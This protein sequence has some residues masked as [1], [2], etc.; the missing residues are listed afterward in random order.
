MLSDDPF[1]IDH[2]LPDVGMVKYVSNVPWKKGVPAIL[3]RSTYKYRM[4]IYAILQCYPNLCIL[5]QASHGLVK[6]A[7]VHTWHNVQ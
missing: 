2:T 4:L 3:C 1:L 7:R 6:Q 5:I